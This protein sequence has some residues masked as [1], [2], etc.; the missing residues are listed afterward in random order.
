MED[1]STLFPRHCTCLSST[2]T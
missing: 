1:G 2:A